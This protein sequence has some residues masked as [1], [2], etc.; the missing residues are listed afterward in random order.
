M[1]DRRLWRGNGRV[2]HSS[3]SGQ[4]GEIPLTEG[5]LL[6]VQVPVADLLAAP[7]GAL[8]R[9]L[10]FGERFCVLETRQGYAFGFAEPSGYVGYIE[11]VHLCAM[12]APTHRVRTFGAHLY[13]TRS[14]K[15]VPALT[16]P[17]DSFLTCSEQ[18]D[19]F[20]KTPHGF[21][22]EQQVSPIEAVTTDAAGTA[23]RFL[24]VPYLWGGDSS[25]GIDCSGLVHAALRAAGR[26][27]P[28]DSDQQEAF[29]DAVP[30]GADLQR[31]DL[32]FWK[33]HVGMM[34]DREHIVHANGHHMCTTA[35]PL[36]RVVE[37]IRD[38]E[39]REISAYCR[40]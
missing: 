35:E 2:A 31:G 18:K 3:L 33:G 21:V 20:W 15:T 22:P 11:A 16:L 37:R 26:D 32:V 6:T 23:L 39:A 9:Q 36:A 7:Q 30:S 14:I 12:E 24:G 19:G 8:D 28:R 29:F 17:F 5:E 10:V 40:P 38:A 25:L 27:C 1:S 34:L 13:P 4:V